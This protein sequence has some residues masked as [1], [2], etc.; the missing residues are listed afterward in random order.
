[1]SNIKTIKQA[2]AEGDGMIIA[3]VAGTIKKVSKLFS[4]TR[5]D[6]GEPYTKQYLTLADSEAQVEVTVW[7]HPDCTPWLGKPCVLQSVMGA[8][9]R[10]GGLSVKQGKSGLELN[11]SESGVIAPPNLAEASAPTLSP[12]PPQPPANAPSEP[13]KAP[14][15]APAPSATAPIPGKP[16][17]DDFVV[18]LTRCFK[19]LRAALPQ[20][21]PVGE[22]QKLA[23]TLFIAEVDNGL[24][25]K[26]GK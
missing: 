10:F 17:H 23:V 22:V 14:T 25:G 26:E 20:D 15:P 16:T 13:A 7:G 3:A 11:M 21:I 2:L 1:M 12:T 24:V 19:D 6:N 5:K 9:N 4:G 8:N 18:C